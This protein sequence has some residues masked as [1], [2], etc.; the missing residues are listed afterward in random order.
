MRIGVTVPAPVGHLNAMTAHTPRLEG[1]GHEVIC[2]GVPDAA[3]GVVAAGLRFEEY[4]GRQ[5][6]PGSYAER[7]EILSRLTGDAGIAYTFRW[8][9]TDAGRNWMRHRLCSSAW[10][11]MGS[12]W[13]KSIRVGQQL[14]ACG[15]ETV[16]CATCG[17]LV[18]LTSHICAHHS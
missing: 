6:P 11:W 2:I 18:A 16:Y 7:A 13:T 5:F 8:K 17:L 12:W 1:R 3:R 10:R 14:P 4:C 9:L 15:S